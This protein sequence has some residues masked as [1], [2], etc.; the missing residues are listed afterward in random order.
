MTNRGESAGSYLYVNGLAVSRPV[1]L[2]R[3]TRLHAVKL[4]CL[5]MSHGLP[6]VEAGLVMAALSQVEC[7]LCISGCSDEELAPRALNSI[8][9]V[10]LINAIF[11]RDAMVNLQGY[12]SASDLE[13]SSVVRAMH[14]DLRGLNRTRDNPLSDSQLSWLEQYVTA[15]RGLLEQSRFRDAMHC[16]ATYRWHTLPR[17][18]LA[19]IWAGIE[20]LFGIDSE[21]VFR[22][23]LHVTQFLAESDSSDRKATFDGV[24]RLYRAR[25]R[26]VHGG[27]LGRDTNAACD[28]SAALLRRLLVQAIERGVL[29][30]TKAFIP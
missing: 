18:R 20:G 29:P 4:T 5:P 3:Y 1:Q 10:L 13:S 16:L 23:S 28:E 17:A 11:D 26:A 19:L 7:E 15:A 9:D 8:W 22:L 12:C 30:D 25:S 21:I 6:V 27:D 14:Y 24:K 2:D